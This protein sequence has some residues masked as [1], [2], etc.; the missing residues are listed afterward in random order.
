MV[1]AD[2]AVTSRDEIQ[3]TYRLPATSEHPVRRLNN[4]VERAGIEPATP[5]LQRRCSP[6]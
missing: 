5:A 3:P 6:S 1:L 4:K 2:I